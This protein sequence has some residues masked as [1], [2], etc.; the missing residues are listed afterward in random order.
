MRSKSVKLEK[1]PKW[2]V[3]SC[4]LKEAGAEA[5]A[6]AEAEALEM[7]PRLPRLAQHPLSHF[8]KSTEVNKYNPIL[9][10]TTTIKQ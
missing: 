1:I 8:Q 10:T 7:S 9:I 6:E 4:E 5:E 3:S 2:S